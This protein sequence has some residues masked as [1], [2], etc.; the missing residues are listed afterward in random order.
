M[1]GVP[2]TPISPANTRIFRFVPAT[3]VATNPPLINLTIVG[4]WDPARTVYRV[5]T[6]SRGAPTFVKDLEDKLVAVIESHS[7]HTVIDIRGGGGRRRMDQWLTPNRDGVSMEWNRRVYSWTAFE[8]S[9]IVRNC[10]QSPQP[11]AMVRPWGSSFELEV[12][13][14][15][16][17]AGLLEPFLLST[18]LI[19][20]DQNYPR[21]Q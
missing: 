5:V 2:I 15:A 10:S 1:P 18:I 12:E 13:L 6:A 21:R 7:N 16:L 8:G 19:Q 17:Q 9:M 4:A 3:P 11:L 20:W 14:D